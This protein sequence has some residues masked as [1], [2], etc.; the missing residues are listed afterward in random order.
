MYFFILILNIMKIKFNET[1][2]LCN[3]EIKN[4]IKEENAL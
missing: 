2:V 1:L 4:E 3:F